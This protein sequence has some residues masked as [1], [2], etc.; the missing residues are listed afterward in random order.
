MNR[1]VLLAWLVTGC[2]SVGFVFYVADDVARLEEE[3]QQV[4]RQIL[5]E[6]RAI[7]VMAAEWSYINRP[8]RLAD[9]ARRH[10][11]LAPLPAE[12]IVQIEDLPMR[13]LATLSLDNGDQS[14]DRAP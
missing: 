1:I 13:P 4:E 12:R 3:L 2:L 7:H 5:K 9:L 11:D 8:D 14:G 10:L 6:Q